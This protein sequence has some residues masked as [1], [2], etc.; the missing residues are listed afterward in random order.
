[1]T[2]ARA[3][4]D[5]GRGESVRER[6]S[7]ALRTDITMGVFVPGQRL[8]EA[9]L[10]AHLDASRTSV[11]ESLRQLEA[12][13]LIEIRPNR[14]PVV[15]RLDWQEAEQIYDVR[16]M[17]EPEVVRLFSLTATDEQLNSMQAA[18]TE[19]EE[20]SSSGL[21]PNLLIQT[22][23]AFYDVMFR[24]CSNQILVEILRGLL[25]RVNLLRS[26]SMSQAGRPKES[27]REMQCILENIRA[28]DTAGAQAA[29]VTHIRNARAHAQAA[30]MAD[31]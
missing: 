23:T 31:A 14:G 24:G 28:S 2:E 15:A 16:E 30:M 12:E 9:E 13:R 29:V 21:H 11:R 6:V 3:E 8:S 22:T 18:L 4:T 25:A 17:I 10:C 5:R 7:N 19:F 27:L 26:R 1:M 20:A